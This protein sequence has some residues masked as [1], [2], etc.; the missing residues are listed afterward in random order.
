MY[1]ADPSFGKII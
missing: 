1:A